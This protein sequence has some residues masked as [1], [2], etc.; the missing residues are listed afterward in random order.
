L[1][2]MN[3]SKIGEKLAFLV[4]RKKTIALGDNTDSKGKV[5][6]DQKFIQENL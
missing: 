4:D 1:V 5:E 3:S 2:I 6:K